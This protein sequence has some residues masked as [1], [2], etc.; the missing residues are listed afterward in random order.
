VYPVWESLV[1]VTRRDFPRSRGLAE[2]AIRGKSQPRDP[3]ARDTQTGADV[4]TF[5][6][7]ASISVVVLDS[8]IAPRDQAAWAF[9]EVD[10]ATAMA[11]FL[12][13][14]VGGGEEIAWVETV[15]LA[16]KLNKRALRFLDSWACLEEETRDPD[17]RGE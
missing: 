9:T 13:A 4:L 12:N 7:V 11:G 2:R 16:R 1:R 8:R 3:R 14:R 6:E 5:L 10:D 17:E 15:P